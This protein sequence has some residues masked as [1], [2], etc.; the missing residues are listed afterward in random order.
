[1][2]VLVTIFFR[3]INCFSSSI[4]FF[5]NLLFSLCRSPT[6]RSDLIGGDWNLKFT[7]SCKFRIRARLLSE[8]ISVAACQK[9]YYVWI[10]LCPLQDFLPFFT[11]KK[12]CFSTFINCLS[13]CLDIFCDIFL[14]SSLIQISPPLHSN[15]MLSSLLSFTKHFLMRHMFHPTNATALGVKLTRQQTHEEQASKLSRAFILYKN[16]LQF[17]QIYFAI[18]DKYICQFWQ[19]PLAISTN[20]FGKFILQFR[21]NFKSRLKI[22]PMKGGS[23]ASCFNVLICISQRS[24]PSLMII[25]WKVR[26]PLFWYLILNI[27]FVLNSQCSV[28]SLMIILRRLEDKKVFKAF[29]VFVF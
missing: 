4:A 3:S 27:V 14:S 17:G 2:V 29:V 28:P 1:M 18:L 26:R 11:N 16:I 15:R 5:L 24:A 23:G 8:L 22:V 7:F 25:P 10:Y 13:L 21:Q 9:A 6:L 20:R 12:T 19:I